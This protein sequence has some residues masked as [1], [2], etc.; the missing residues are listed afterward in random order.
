M[1]GPAIRRAGRA[2]SRADERAGAARRAAGV[3]IDG[4]PPRREVTV[5]GAWGSGFPRRA[6]AGG[7]LTDRAGGMTPGRWLR[8]SG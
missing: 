8:F 2:S 3:R 5:V 6:A 4:E 1:P 7:R